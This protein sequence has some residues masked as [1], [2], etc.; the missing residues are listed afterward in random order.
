MCLIGLMEEDDMK[1]GTKM[2]AFPASYEN[3]PMSAVRQAPPPDPPEDE[4]ETDEDLEDSDVIGD[5][6]AD[7]DQEAA[8]DAE[9]SGAR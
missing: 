9:A 3:D 7:P 5:P 6:A 4:D 8:V 2:D 1:A